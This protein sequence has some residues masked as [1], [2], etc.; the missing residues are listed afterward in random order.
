MNEATS[1][2]CL[3]TGCTDTGYSRCLCIRHYIVAHRLVHKGI[4]SWAKLVEQG[5]AA[6]VRARLRYSDAQSFFLDG[7]TVTKEQGND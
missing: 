5:K 2:K 4:T 6:P 7:N 3:V 1:N